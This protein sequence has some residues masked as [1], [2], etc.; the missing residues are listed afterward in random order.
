[1]CKS[2]FYGVLF[3]TTR[4]R[5]LEASEPIEIMLRK[6]HTSLFS[7]H[8]IV[9]ALLPGQYTTRIDV[10]RGYHAIQMG[11]LKWLGRT[12]REFARRSDTSAGGILNAD[13]QYQLTQ[14]LRDSVHVALRVAD[15]VDR[16]V[17]SPRPSCTTFHDVLVPVLC[18]TSFW[19]DEDK[20]IEFFKALER[21]ADFLQQTRRHTLDLVTKHAAMRYVLE[22]ERNELGRHARTAVTQSLT[23]TRMA[24]GGAPIIAAFA[25]AMIRQAWAELKVELYMK[26]SMPSYTWQ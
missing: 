21:A 24:Y 3:A 20:M 25:L 7:P 22:F 15:I 5:R 12:L 1:M 10:T 13:N 4:M 9:V 18:G 23:R 16:T 19:G 2:I 11:T 17:Q 6:P 8:C 26:I 14:E